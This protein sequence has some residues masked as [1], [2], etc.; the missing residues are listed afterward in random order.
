MNDGNVFVFSFYGVKDGFV[1]NEFFVGRFLGGN[2][3]FN[4]YRVVW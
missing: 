3:F 4:K 1:I 2:V